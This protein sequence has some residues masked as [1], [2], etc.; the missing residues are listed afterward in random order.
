MNRA[1]LKF[2]INK[3]DIG[4]MVGASAFILTTAMVVALLA[5]CETTEKDETG[6]NYLLQ[7]R[8]RG[9]EVHGEVGAV[10]GRGF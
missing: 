1:G 10:Y 5:G 7:E 8:P 9:G 3:I 4:G 2:R 6:S